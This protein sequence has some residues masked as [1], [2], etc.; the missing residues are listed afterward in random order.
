MAHHISIKRKVMWATAAC[1]LVPLTTYMCFSYFY[2][3]QDYS[4]K[5]YSLQRMAMNFVMQELDNNSFY[6]KFTE[7]SNNRVMRQDLYRMYKVINLATSD[8]HNHDYT[9]LLSSN[10][11]SLS[12]EPTY[13]STS[14]TSNMSKLTPQRESDDKQASKALGGHDQED[15]SASLASDNTIPTAT[16]LNALGSISMG[17]TATAASTYEANSPLSTLLPNRS[18]R[19]SYNYSGDRPEE[20]SLNLGSYSTSNQKYGLNVS[21]S[22]SYNQSS[23]LFAG[24]QA[25]NSISASNHNSSSSALSGLSLSSVQNN[26]IRTISSNRSN[27]NHASA[28]A[29]NASATSSNATATSSNTT[30]DSSTATSSADAHASSTT[31]ARTTVASATDAHASR[32]IADT[33]KSN[34]AAN[35]SADAQAAK[36]NTN[37]LSSPESSGKT[38]MPSEQ[39]NQQNSP[40]D[41]NHDSQAVAELESNLDTA[42]EYKAAPELENKLDAELEKQIELENKSE[43]DDKLDPEREAKLKSEVESVLEGKVGAKQERTRKVSNAALGTEFNLPM[44]ANNYDLP[45]LSKEKSEFHLLPKSWYILQAAEASTLSELSTLSTDSKPTSVFQEGRRA[46]SQHDAASSNTNAASSN[47]NAASSNTNAASRDTNLAA[48][49]AQTAGT[50]S[51]MAQDNASRDNSS[52]LNADLETLFN[53]ERVVSAQTK[54]N[55]TNYSDN[56][57]DRPVDASQY[58]A[59]SAHASL[60]RIGEHLNNRAS[61]AQA[62]TKVMEAKEA[63]N[64]ALDQVQ[65]Q[66][67]NGKHDSVQ[68][69]APDSAPSFMQSATDTARRDNTTAIKNYS[70]VDEPSPF[71][72]GAKQNN[73]GNNSQTATAHAAIN[74]TP[75]ANRNTLFFTSIEQQLDAV[76]N[77]TSHNQPQS[78][79]RS[80]IFNPSSASNRQLPGRPFNK[81]IANYETPFTEGLPGTIVDAQSVLK[82]WENK[83]QN[84]NLDNKIVAISPVESSDHSSLPNYHYQYHI[85]RAEEA[86]HASHHTDNRGTPNNY[87]DALDT[88]RSF[89]PTIPSGETLLAANKAPQDKVHNAV[90]HNDIAIS[91][92]AHSETTA[93]DSNKKTP[94]PIQDYAARSHNISND[95][96]CEESSHRLTLLRQIDQLH[97]LGFI[98]FSLNIKNPYLDLYVDDNNRRFAQQMKEKNTSLQRLLYQNSIPDDGYFITMID[99]GNHPKKFKPTVGMLANAPAMIARQYEISS[100]LGSNNN[101]IMD[102]SALTTDLLDQALP[103]ITSNGEA[104]NTHNISILSAETIAL[105]S[106]LDGLQNQALSENSDFNGN[107]PASSN[108][109]P[110]ELV[111][112]SQA[113]L[114][115][116]S[117]AT[118]GTNPGIN[119]EANPGATPENSP[120]ATPENGPGAIA[121]NAYSATAPRDKATP[122]TAF[123]SAPTA[124]TAPA[125]T[126]ATSNNIDD[127]LDKALGEQ[128]AGNTTTGDKDSLDK[129]SLKR[130]LINPDKIHTTRSHYFTESNNFKDWQS[131]QKTSYYLGF[132]GK[133]SFDPNQLIVIFADASHLKKNNEISRQMVVNTINELIQVLEMTSP[134]EITLL[135]SYQHAVAGN[136]Q[137]ADIEQI[138]TPEV[139]QETKSQGFYQGYN[140]QRN[141][142]IS[143]G[144]FRPYDCFIVVTSSRYFGTEL[145]RSFIIYISLIGLGFTLL[146]CLIMRIYARRLS[147][148]IYNIANKIKLVPSLIQDPNSLNIICEGLPRRSDELGL[149]SLYMRFMSKTLYQV[150]NDTLRQKS[151]SLLEQKEQK[152]LSDLRGSSLDEQLQRTNNYEHRLA[153]HYEAVPNYIGDFF[154]VMELD[155]SRLA[156]FMGTIYLPSIRGSTLALINT[157]VIR[158]LLQLTVSQGL[159]LSQVVKEFNDI[160]AKGQKEKAAQLQPQDSAHQN[161]HAANGNSAPS[162]HN[163]PS[164]NSVHGNQNTANS[165]NAAS[166][167]HDTQDM[168]CSLVIIVIDQESGRVEYINAGHPSPLVHHR[169]KMQADLLEVEANP[170]LGKSTDATF[171]SISFDLQEGDMFLLYSQG[172]L[173][174]CNPNDVPLGLAGLRK[175]VKEEMY[176]RTDNTV[177]NLTNQIRHYT[178][179]IALKR[180]YTV[181]CYQY[182][183]TKYPVSGYDN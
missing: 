80:P 109:L 49:E 144:Y 117:E 180:D 110:R 79:I 50:V 13:T 16:V 42:P 98:A 46:S 123:A 134:L 35:S 15:S 61:Q 128:L 126:P 5:Q 75:T 14:S 67:N 9:E 65:A 178:G 39:D 138:L 112:R 135:D 121:P 34:I 168:I 119:P 26:P 66:H 8:P 176:M 136:L 96:S 43:L 182:Q 31:V 44:F 124:V 181:L 151:V 131:A 92:I 47:T 156:V 12:E 102:N 179:R 165:L 163:A 18:T 78:N 174:C 69:S 41:N 177:F 161:P 10:P 4:S 7:L 1:C 105:L 116:N 84:I 100:A 108:S 147:R 23:S 32:T 162:A 56:L 115:A 89:S 122:E 149:L 143:I 158:Q 133:L 93:S 132:V 167:T 6:N 20:T 2:L 145:N 127:S 58:G 72:R 86:I 173:E 53:H 76:S 54:A 172:L 48:R 150:F 40:Q 28:T 146:A 30:T 55:Y 175:L 103:L 160:I 25:L 155:K 27:P 91:G 118:P 95:N 137:K 104:I 77:P 52:S 51:N 36:G 148:D 63:P 74:R 3:N 106:S 113:S 99:V 59:A 129:E 21:N 70:S 114:R 37:S 183:P 170:S 159:T 60:D 24:Y 57:P 83:P 29:A 88:K 130:G 62:Q 97:S 85:T 45:E 164:G 107:G 71:T 11:S 94:A 153:Y 68:D 139:I 142:Y 166:T 22:Q 120:G 101:A 33:D 19:S 152:L 17:R 140:E 73:Q 64:L 171:N 82:Q 87:H 169:Y 81:E 111:P 38:K 141:Q 154:D 90:A 157:C 125:P